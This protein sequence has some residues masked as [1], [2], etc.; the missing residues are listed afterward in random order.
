MLHS[1]LN[2]LGSDAELSRAAIEAVPEALLNSGVP[3]I[4]ELQARFGRVA[5]A[6]RRASLVP[7]NGG[8]WHHALATVITALKLPESGPH[9]EGD[10]IDAKI[11]R[12]Q[13]YLSRADLST[14]IREVESLPEGVARTLCEDWVTS[15]K[16][17]LILDQASRILTADA[18]LLQELSIPETS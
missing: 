12:A 4:P 9:V 10:T 18:I 2:E 1:M 15:A 6:C 11:A 16:G 5:T 8:F 14:A 13:Y 17:R 3:T 7:D